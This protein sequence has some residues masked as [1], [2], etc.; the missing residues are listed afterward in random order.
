MQL[1]SWHGVL[2]FARNSRMQSLYAQPVTVSN[3][4]KGQGAFEGIQRCLWPRQ[5]DP[6]FLVSDLKVSYDQR[7]LASTGQ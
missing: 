7:T 3:E 2:D 1:D 4:Q 5:I 6:S